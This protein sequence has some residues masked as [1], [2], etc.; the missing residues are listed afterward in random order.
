MI[1]SY[2]VGKYSGPGDCNFS[3]V[4]IKVTL[5]RGEVHEAFE[6]WTARLT[7]ANMDCE[8][9]ARPVPVDSNANEF[10]SRG[11]SRGSAAVAISASPLDLHASLCVQCDHIL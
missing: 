2:N 7:I 3:D 11:G 5:S 4:Q 6:A 1:C 10:L 8:A 9:N